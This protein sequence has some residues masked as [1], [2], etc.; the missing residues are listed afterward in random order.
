MCKLRSDTYEID[1][2]VPLA[3]GGTNDD[4]N[5]QLLCV[6]CHKEKTTLEKLNAT[7]K[8]KD[9]EASV[10]N[11]VVLENIVTNKSWNAFQFVEK[12][13]Y[14]YRHREQDIDKLQPFKI[15]TIKCRRNI[16]LLWTWPG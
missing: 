12:N 6:D 15:D 16:L 8:I 5:L 10:F 11:D 13:Q 2:I 7:Y 14:P 1:H 4:S 3:S 9:N